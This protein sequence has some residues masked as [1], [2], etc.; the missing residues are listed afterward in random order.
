MYYLS[1][2]PPT[3]TV[4]PAFHV[5]K[6]L[7]LLPHMKA[8]EPLSLLPAVNNFY[9][10]PCSWSRDPKAQKNKILKLRQHLS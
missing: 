1:Y 7:L 9:D 4:L 10:T 2:K 8:G 5:W 6:I 3:Q